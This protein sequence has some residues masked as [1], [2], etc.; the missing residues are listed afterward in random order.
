MKT[1]L[2][3]IAF[4][5]SAVAVPLDFTSG[6][7]ARH[8]TESSKFK[9]DL[10]RIY[11]YD[12]EALTVTTLRGT[13]SEDS[14]LYIKAQV[15]IEALTKCDLS[16]Q[17]R[18]VSLEQTDPKNP[19]YRRVAPETVKFRKD[20]ER[21]TLRFSFQDGRIETLCPTENEPA[22][23]L[24]IKRGVLS[25]IQ[26]SM[27][28]L[29]TNENTTETDVAGKCRVE[30]MYTGR[31]WS[32]VNVKKYK[33]LATCSS[34]GNSE[35]AVQTSPFSSDMPGKSLP[36]LRGTQ[37]C[38]QS[39]RNNR[40]D[41]VQCTESHIFKPF[42]R[43]EKDAITKS[44]QKL[45]F[46]TER[47]GSFTG[48]DYR[49]T[50]HD[51]LFDHSYSE[52][53]NQLKEREAVQVMLELCEAA[54]N[55]IRPS[56]PAKFSRLVYKLRELDYQSLYS[57]YKRADSI[58]QG[59]K[60]ARQ[61][62]VDAIPAV[63]ST[64]SV[65]LIKELVTKK[66]VS[67]SEAN[68]WLSSLTFLQNPTAEMIGELV[69]IIDGSYGQAIL[70]VSSLAHT[71][72]RSHEDCG[73]VPEMK[74]LVRR[75][76]ANL[77]NKCLAQ[78]SKTVLLSLKAIGNIGVDEDV[79]DILH[80][81]YSNPQLDIETRLAAIKAFRRFSC[82]ISREN[83]LKIYTNYNENT[84]LRIAA[85]MNVMRCPD[86]RVINIIKETLEK[87]VV[88][89]VGSFVWTHLTSIQETSNPIKQ[90]I[91]DILFNVYLM[92]KFNTDIRKFS[93][94][95][96]GSFFMDSI[97]SGVHVDGDV[98]FTPESYLPRSGM[99]NLTIDL[100]GNSLNLFEIGGRM[101][102]MEEL[103][104]R[105]FG[106]EGYF[107][108][109]TVDKMLKKFREKRSIKD[110]K[111]DE[112]EAVY[113]ANSQF[114]KDVSGSIYMKMFGNELF[115]SRLEELGTL[116]QKE[117]LLDMVLR[118][119]KEQDVE[120]T[121]S[122]MF[123]DTTYTI[124]TS[125]GLPLRLAVNGTATV[126]LKMGGR[127]DV[128]S[129]RLVDIRGHLQPSGAVELSTL[130]TV[131]ANVAQSGLKVA[132]VLHSSTVMDG[133][134]EVKDGKVLRVQ[135]N[136]PRDN[137]E[138]V[139]IQ[140]KIYL[141]HGDEEQ[142]AR[143][144]Q[145]D[146]AEV[147]KCTSK[148]LGRML[149]MELCGEM[150][151]PVPRGRRGDAPLFPFSGPASIKLSLR[152]ADP[153]L[154]SYNFE[155]SLRNDEVGR[156][157]YI[158]RAVV[159]FNTPQSSI[160]REMTLDIQLNQ[161][162]KSFDFKLRS[163]FKKF[164]V[165]A[166][167]NND[168]TE[169][170]IDIRF[171]MDDKEQ[172][173]VV[174]SM[175]TDRSST[176]L[177]LTPYLEVRIPSRRLVYTKGYVAMVYGKKYSGQL[178]IQDLTEKPVVVKGDLDIKDR[179]SYE[180]EI[181]IS[182][183]F[184]DTTVKGNVNIG[185]SV[186][187]K[188]AIDY[189][190][191]EGQRENFD[192]TG[193]FRDFSANSLT[194]YTGAITLQSTARPE[195]ATAVNWE[196]QST[197]GHLENLFDVSFGDGR[198]IEVHKI[199]I[200]EILRYEG[201]LADNK[202]A[203][204]LKF[205]YP[206]RDIDYVL[207]LKH[208]NNDNSLSNTL[209]I[210]YSG[211]REIM[212]AIELS[213]ANTRFLQLKADAQLQYPGRE[214][215]L[216]GE[217][218]ENNRNDY[219][220]SINGQWQKEQVRM[221]ASYKNKSGRNQLRHEG[222]VEIILPR[223]SPINIAG[224]IRAGPGQ[225]AVTTN[226]EVARKKYSLQGDYSTT[227][228]WNHRVSG[229][230][231]F[232]GNSYSTVAVLEGSRNGMKAT[233][234]TNLEGIRHITGTVDFTNTK[235]TKTGSLDLKWDADHNQD[236]RITIDTEYQDI[237]TGQ[238]GAI[239]VKVLN[240]VK[241]SFNNEIDTRFTKGIFRLNTR[242]ELEWE[243]YKKIAMEIKSDNYISSYKRK[244]RTDITLTTPFDGFQSNNVHLS[245]SDD[246]QEWK[247][248]FVIEQNSRKTTLTSEGRYYNNRASCF[249][250]ST[251]KF[252]NPN[253]ERMQ[254]DIYHEMSTSDMSNKLE[255]QWGYNRKISAGIYGSLIGSGIRG[256]INFTS[257]FETFRD[258]SA[259]VLHT[260][261]QHHVK[262][263][264]EI[265]WDVQKKIS[266]DFDGKHALENNKRTCSIKAEVATPFTGFES[267]LTNIV[268]TNDGRNVNIDTEMNW[269]Y[270]RVSFGMQGSNKN[271]YYNT[272][273]NGKVY[274][275][276]S[277]RG[278]ENIECSGLYESY[279]QTFKANIEAI[280]PGRQKVSVSSEGTFRSISDAT[281]KL[282]A[283]TP[284]HNLE[285]ISFDFSHKFSDNLKTVGEITYGNR[286][287]TMDLSGTH[288]I[289][290]GERRLNGALV[291]T[292]P[293]V[294]FEEVKITIAHDTNQ[295]DRY[296]SRLEAS[297]DRNVF[298]VMHTFTL[299]DSLNFQTQLEIFTPFENFR[300]AKI[301]TKQSFH[302]DAFKHNT[303]FILNRQAPVDILVEFLNE[304]DRKGQDI[305]ARF[306]LLTPSDI[307]QS[308][309]IQATYE[310][311]D[312]EYKPRL[313]IQWNDSKKITLDGYLANDRMQR[314]EGSIIY[315]SPFYGYE[316]VTLSG[317]YDLTSEN[318]T[319][320]LSFEYAPQE[321]GKLSL[322]GF[323]FADRRTGEANLIFRSPIR[324][325]EKLIAYGK[326]I[327]GR[328]EKSGE[329]SF[330]WPKDQ[331]MKV[332]T[333]VSYGRN[334]IKSSVSFNSPFQG[335]EAFRAEANID[336]NKN[337]F[338]ST[339]TWGSGKEIDFSFEYE[340]TSNLFTTA[341]ILRTPFSGYEDMAVNGRIQKNYYEYEGLLTTTWAP[342]KQITITGKVKH[343]GFYP[344]EITVDIK[345]PFHL[346]NNIKFSSTMKNLD[347]RFSFN[348]NVNWNNEIYD[349]N[350][351]FDRT[352]REAIEGKFN[353]NTPNPDHKISIE[354]HLNENN[355]QKIEGS[356]KFTTPF[357]T[358]SPI[359]I[360]GSLYDSGEGKKLSINGNSQNKRFSITGDLYNNRN[361]HITGKLTL[362]LPFL[363][364]SNIDMG[365]DIQSDWNSQFEASAKL[366][367]GSSV[368]GTKVVLKNSNVIKEMVLEIESSLLFTNKVT[369]ELELT[370]NSNA[371]NTALKLYTPYVS[372]R[373]AGSLQKIQQGYSV[374][375]RFESPIIKNGPFS[376]DATY[377]SEG[378]EGIKLDI[379]LGTKFDKHSLEVVYNYGRDL[380]VLS[381]K[382][383]SSLLVGRSVEFEGRYINSNN[384]EFETS[385]KLTTPYSSHSVSGTLKLYDTE[386]ESIVRIETPLFNPKSLTVTSKFL[387]KNYEVM[388]GNF[389][390][391]TPTSELRVAGNI[392]NSG[393]KG[394]EAF[395]TINTPFEILKM[396]RVDTKFLN[397]NFKNIEGSF[398]A[399]TSTY[400]F[401]KISISGKVRH[402]TGMYDVSINTKLPFRR[403]SNINL[404]ATLHHNN[405]MTFVNPRV[406][407]TLQ[408]N[409]YTVYSNYRYF[410]ENLVA[411]A[412]YEL[413]EKPQVEF[414]TTIKFTPNNWNSEITVKTPF[415]G[416][417]NYN[418]V[419]TYTIE[420]ELHNIRVVFK[421]PVYRTSVVNMSFRYSDSTNM[422]GEI[423][424]TTP[425]RGWENIE[426]NIILQSNS[427]R[428]LSNFQYS[429]GNNQKIVF[430]FE[431]KI[432][433]KGFSG[434][435]KII[436]PLQILKNTNIEYKV[437]NKDN[438]KSE[439]EIIYNSRKI[440]I[441]ETSSVYEP[442]GHHRNV[443]VQLPL[444][445][446]GF[447]FDA[448]SLEAGIEMKVETNIPSRKM[449]FH[450][451]Y[452][453]TWSHFSH[454]TELTWDVEARRTISYEARLVES[455]K[456]GTD[457]FGKLSLPGRTFELKGET[458]PLQNG[459]NINVE[460]SWDAARDVNK[461]LGLGF[462]YEDKS[463]KAVT[464]YKI[465]MTMKHPRLSKDL[466]VLGDISVSSSELYAKAEVDYSRYRQNKMAVEVR[467]KN[468]QSWGESKY[469][470]EA[471]A[472]HPVTNIDI[473][474]NGQFVN[475][476]D[477]Y[478]F[479]MKFDYLDRNRMKRVQELKTKIM[480]LRQEI[481]FEM[482]AGGNQLKMLGRMFNRDH[483]FTAALE[484]Q[485]N[486]YSP[487]HSHFRLSKRHMNMDLNITTPENNGIHIRAALPEDAAQFQI[488]H[489]KHGESVSD[490]LFDFGLEEAKVL[491]GRITWRREMMD[492]VKEVVS[493]NYERFNEMY[494]STI[495][496][497]YDE[498]SQELNSKT[499]LI[500][501]SL[502]QELKPFYREMQQD[503]SNLEDEM[504]LVSKEMFK[505]YRR[506]EFYIKDIINGIEMVAES[507]C[508]VICKSGEIFTMASYTGRV[509]SY[510]FSCIIEKSNLILETIVD[511]YGRAIYGAVRIIRDFSINIREWTK[512]VTI[513]LTDFSYL[514]VRNTEWFIHRYT[515]FVE[516]YFSR[517]VTTYLGVKEIV[518]DY[519]DYLAEEIYNHPYYIAL[520]NYI[521]RVKSTIAAFHRSYYSNMYNN[522]KQGLSTSVSS[523]S[524]YYNYFHRHPHVE[525]IKEFSRDTYNKGI[526]V[527]RYLGFDYIIDTIYHQ[528]K[529]TV[530]ESVKELVQDWSSM[531]SGFSYTFKPERG[532]VGFDIKL[533]S[534][535]ENLRDLLD[536]TTY[537]IYQHLQDLK[538]KLIN[539]D[540]YV[541]DSYYTM[542]RFVN[543]KN[544][545]PPFTA[546][547]M[548]AGNDHYITFDK[549]HFDFAG[550]C[551]YLLARDFADGNFTVA[552]TYTRNNYRVVKKS[553]TVITDDAKI[554]IS[555]DYKV[556]ISDTKVELPV[557]IGEI[558]AKREDNTVHIHYARGIDVRCN[559]IH[560]V[561]SLEM[562]GFYF[563]K[564]AG[565]FGTYDNEPQLDMMTPERRL[566]DQPEKFAS[567][568][569]IGS[570]VCRPSSP[571]RGA[572]VTEEAKER[573]NEIFH[574]SSSNLRPCFQ[575]VNPEPYFD[576]CVRDLSEVDIQRK[577]DA[578]CTSSAAYRTHCKVAGVKVKM[579]KSCVR[580]ENY[581]GT[582]LLEGETSVIKKVPTKVA[583]IVFIVEE[584]ACNKDVMPMLGKMARGVESSYRQKG[585][586]DI[587][588]TVVGFGGNGVHGF[589]HVHTSDGQVF[590][591]IRS[592]DS[593]LTSL[594]IGDG[595]SNIFHAIRFA[596]GLPFHAGATKSFVLAKCTTCEAEDTKADYSEILQ[597]LLDSEITLHI[598]MDHEFEMKSASKSKKA[599]R[600]LG[601]DLNY[602]YSLK[603]AKDKQLKG[604][605]AILSQVKVPKDHCVPLALESKGSFFTTEK[606]TTN[607]KKA[608]K[609]ID[610]VTRR[611]ALTAEQSQCQTCGCI[612]TEDGVGK[613]MCQACVS[614]PII[615]RD[616]PIYSNKEVGDS[617]SKEVDEYDD[618]QN[619]D[620]ED[621]MDLPLQGKKR[622]MWKEY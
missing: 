313:E 114:H 368:H 371:Y 517:L 77:G 285:R 56:V 282:L 74:R 15:E 361:R 113:N 496:D 372:H 199:K 204:T 117:G 116:S 226:I 378:Y 242:G 189:K 146:R 599:K 100:F 283:T 482:K 485:L 329:I 555:P 528:L 526:D 123:L 384:R 164:G 89:Q 588:Y 175:G 280:L 118:L 541:W 508:S 589:P 68:M 605:K 73:S 241:A 168:E 249:L 161:Q 618:D 23:V 144:K 20:L 522:F 254:M 316:K 488:N 556:T 172:L 291:V 82:S 293:Y 513:Y 435:L 568:W 78:D 134:V 193:K 271:T 263:Q 152:K 171:T 70:G 408:Q 510:V 455:S 380:V 479:D 534:T 4:V 233:F 543:P 427:K 419:I 379:S 83:L 619:D 53:T 575:Q 470:I 334:D 578:I 86:L 129:F 365:F 5:A 267:A 352:G 11:T 102:G 463:G 64:A 537:P 566:V 509:F 415:R 272:N 286:K 39:F 340:I 154:T 447:A 585:Y 584:K 531:V 576:M 298:Q 213:K 366:T 395:F 595:P 315:S 223:T 332:Y 453:S 40:V 333:E 606:L 444:A 587:R 212:S 262:S 348:S 558:V 443:N 506:N 438:T 248:A 617:N 47:Q 7:C 103:V 337:M 62:V 404:L 180:G 532:Q 501:R 278:Y 191:L 428:L 500:K 344:D 402:N 221:T 157:E 45:T 436:S 284:I 126:G 183:Y 12:Y 289:S 524:N 486:D 325:Y 19:A 194:K 143:G 155:A 27:N 307:F 14:Q 351:I 545:I 110:N 487:V 481:H 142:E 24:N 133:L 542:I 622:K 66:E 200:Q 413:N 600:L 539:E 225:Y 434:E 297:Y 356:F 274:F 323:L 57:I 349:M 317:M 603:D 97:N 18:R 99:L 190:I 311:N 386:I 355:A 592:I 135:V 170:K 29:F 279:R 88:N 579:P 258:L 458:E 122:F 203:A 392:R 574:D 432:N 326:Y 388:E 497:V 52:P 577:S 163:P 314:V 338:H 416:Y 111:I 412:G 44:V 614:N 54:K 231:I 469:T 150:S 158:R 373:F 138:I 401:P 564:T 483:E 448:K 16:L 493:N 34:R 50:R 259:S 207:R 85:Y 601:L 277:F 276:S 61:F 331:K 255:F 140:S 554:E 22:W 357:E 94:Y 112:L 139:D 181:G 80:D 101:Q 406:T 84:E 294:G 105:F 491:R 451:I 211:R 198:R 228:V 201:S 385:L 264:V 167:Y 441:L 527:A 582:I 192:I 232:P 515:P 381:G 456:R 609:F 302:S 462:E 304:H 93:R 275:T 468:I 41:S 184:L 69:D 520:N 586:S 96:E 608:K 215:R 243:P 236:K 437:L 32:T 610:V 310:D 227:S 48:N 477:E 1:L 397:E 308:L 256:G 358:I 178:T 465:Q 148:Y 3:A 590:A 403:Y 461:R 229:M 475:N 9:Y 127:F 36:L 273:V 567:S 565:L 480:K 394:M 301:I 439:V 375:V 25:M 421:D 422:G 125:S 417:E 55:D 35:S 288:S 474:V 612:A 409:Q 459:K 182:S 449:L 607:A 209:N 377:S 505:M 319:G 382:V 533:P 81:C 265:Q 67:D 162:E 121:K 132:A 561:C 253:Q 489:I 8:C 247:N 239:T 550:E 65:R 350:I 362:D 548:I 208:R 440:F 31:G 119:A 503:I 569:Q 106:P 321:N 398:V 330:Q 268:Y 324:N 418:L 563:G 299:Q 216:A 336:Q 410:G 407:F 339:L 540:L 42:S 75:L 46:N 484:Q 523:L 136:M 322:S 79:V 342:T 312:R 165:N 400:T 530:L 87:E 495:N 562:S 559:F 91:K 76:V 176:S 613:M 512:S 570:A 145:E 478:I 516:T 141:V 498:A 581:D 30:Y 130:M 616:I 188:L 360:S 43:H 504:R 224:Y 547:A 399:Q 186:F 611:M 281:V 507:V 529:D 593:A 137:I 572:V 250:Q 347:R 594:T 549:F 471:N 514:I 151:F 519:V 26:N 430:N 536:I 251:V 217:V 544:W 37:E 235:T 95:F 266:F 602:A 160:D 104:E 557:E 147:S 521:N 202:I 252:Y 327:S 59:N 72:C 234:D 426:T 306:K 187:T 604:D 128:R 546:H 2:L 490:V 423:T 185:S 369:L 92:N 393:W 431:N 197:D 571:R 237:A 49:P 502:T 363:Y 260:Q 525:S 492:D 476:N 174:T 553:L 292:T 359:D 494:S 246:G 195:Y 341:L 287:I 303:N 38:E 343:N 405:D 169:K 551:S 460:F 214:M 597:T 257:P 518:K 219:H 269:N 390:I 120:L 367:Y 445:A 425:F 598:L 535:H 466:V 222:D 220:V 295:Q 98:I 109:K 238:T 261:D 71:F 179:G 442:Q 450:T 499:S 270:K 387:N 320:E 370:S 90:D 454:A 560:D 429:W 10:G 21:N 173:T 159:S 620:F 353:L 452:Q 376:F 63:G 411:A 107:P 149:G 60:N 218:T 615:V 196:M 396:A 457:I 383:E 433:S 420:Q 472:R 13:F 210:K 205:Q 153:T 583:D 166:K 374:E 389:L 473:S 346:Y 245:H 345:T 206:Q 573:C 621:Y 464:A 17:L 424:L 177:R 591:S 318:K 290:Y 552:I 296:N 538:Y 230:L 156:D 115:Y 58:C 467:G 300:S 305:K 414:S 6:Q 33:N 131:D 354:G 328:N 28:D 335:Y 108:Q 244:I 391:K 309:L 51:L 596:A 511:V 240:A 580:C 446:V 364:S 124:P